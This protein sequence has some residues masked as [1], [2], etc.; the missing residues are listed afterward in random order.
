M[1]I[2]IMKKEWRDG[3]SYCDS[4][5]ITS[6]LADF[7][8]EDKSLDYSRCRGDRGSGGLHQEKFSKNI[9]GF[10]YNQGGEF[11]EDSPPFLISA[12][13]SHSGRILFMLWKSS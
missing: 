9:K 2:I 4:C 11:Y 6:I 8:S 7:S 1:K 3:Y 12:L 5:G 10:C 13:N